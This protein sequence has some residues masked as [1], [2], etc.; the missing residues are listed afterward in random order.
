MKLSRKRPV[1]KEPTANSASNVEDVDK[2]KKAEHSNSVDKN[3]KAGQTK[4]SRF[5]SKA[6]LPSISEKKEKET[7]MAPKIVVRNED[8]IRFGFTK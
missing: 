2:N 4:I 6:L 8:N 7:L 5:F 1:A 3:K